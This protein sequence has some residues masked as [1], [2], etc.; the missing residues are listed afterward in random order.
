MGGG[1]GV[2]G[3]GGGGPWGGIGSGRRERLETLLGRLGW[4][5]A[6][7]IRASILSSMSVIICRM[8][9]SMSTLGGGEIGLWVGNGIPVGSGPPPHIVAPLGPA[10]CDVASSA[11]LGR[12]CLSYGWVAIGRAVEYD[13]VTV[14]KVAGRGEF[15]VSAGVCGSNWDDDSL[16]KLWS[17]FQD[18]TR[19]FLVSA[20][21][22]G[23]GDE[24]IREDCIY[25]RAGKV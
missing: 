5:N 10:S 13:I 8:A 2:G 22:G 25:V 14:V 4:T 18:L 11:G 20:V 21:E 19:E 24:E 16:E 15:R 17:A 12:L 6:C 1:G 23:V 7:C 9:A 3:P